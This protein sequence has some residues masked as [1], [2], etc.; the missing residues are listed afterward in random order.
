MFQLL[1]YIFVICSIFITAL[2]ASHNVIVISDFKG[3][4]VRAGILC[5]IFKNGTN[6][7]VSIEYNIDKRQ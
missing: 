1:L 4:H 3:L 5:T 6:N 7:F 2:I